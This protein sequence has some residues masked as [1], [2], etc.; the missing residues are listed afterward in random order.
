MQAIDEVAL[1]SQPR[2]K[3]PSARAGRRRDCGPRSCVSRRNRAA[4]ML[5]ATTR[6]AH[7][8]VRSGGI[9]VEQ[10]EIDLPLR[11]IDPAQ[12]HA[13]RIAHL[14]APAG[15]LPH[16]SHAAVLQFPVVAG[17]RRDVH[18]T[19]DGHF[20]QLH[21]QP[22]L[23]RA[24][25]GRLEGLAR[26][27]AAD[28]G[29]SGI[30]SHRAPPRRRA[31]RAAN[32]PPRASAVRRCCSVWP[33]ADCGSD[34]RFDRAMHEQ[35]GIAADRR[36]EVR[37][38]LERQAEV[39]DVGLLIYGLRQGAYHQTLEQLAV[40]AGRQPLDQLAKLARASASPKTSRPPAAHS[41]TF[42]SSV[43]R[44][45]SGCPCTR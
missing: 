17:D 23:E 10:L 45:S 33:E 6:C 4:P 40:R 21:E 9:G 19:V 26:P 20:L 36:C 25:D 1:R 14:P 31:A 35:V 5:T 2:P 15:A 30:P 28:T 37:I 32:S 16:E 3:A 39:A 12:A 42:C 7:R 34:G 27:A 29:T 44:F 43:T 41:M 38:L 13:H 11:E 8:A 18:Q 24:R 22:E